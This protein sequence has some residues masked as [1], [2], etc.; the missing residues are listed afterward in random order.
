MTD[1]RMRWILLGVLLLL[2]ANGT[3]NLALDASGR[4][5]ALH[6]ALELVTTLVGMSVAA[7]LWLA[8]RTAAR[9]EA[10]ALQS[11]KARRAERDAWRESARRA[12]EGLGHA[13]SA[14]FDIWELTPTEREVAILL[15]KGYSHKRIADIT[16]RKERTVRQHGVTVY[17]KAGLSGRAELA[18]FFLEDLMLPAVQRTAVSDNG[19]G[20]AEVV[21]GVARAPS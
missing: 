2:G 19:Q 11:L 9:A 14:Q 7:L 13:I 18:A 6:V 1:E 10:Q 17:Q 3:V 16:S 20:V 21:P 15:L 5:P 4:W 8:W 12:L